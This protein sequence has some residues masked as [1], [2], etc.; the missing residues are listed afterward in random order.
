MQNGALIIPRHP[1]QEAAGWDQRFLRRHQE[2]FTHYG[3]CGWPEN[4]CHKK[5]RQA[6]RARPEH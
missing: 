3:K 2:A 1:E 6:I 4:A 5:A